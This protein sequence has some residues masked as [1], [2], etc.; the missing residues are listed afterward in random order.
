MGPGFVCS[1]GC[2]AAPLTGG[3]WLH[4]IDVQDL[5]GTVVASLAQCS[6]RPAGRRTWV[7]LAKNLIFRLF[8][9][10]VLFANVIVVSLGCSPN[11]LVSPIRIV[12]TI[13][14]M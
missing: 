8:Q 10:N 6:V 12:Q 3:L 11:V 2:T 13:I 7:G 4:C 14:R 9:N 5:L 1:R